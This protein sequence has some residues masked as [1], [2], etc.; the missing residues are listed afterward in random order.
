MKKFLLLPILALFSVACS[1][2]TEELDNY[3]NNAFRAAAQ[4]TAGRGKVSPCF[5]KVTAYPSLELQ[6]DVIGTGTL[7]FISQPGSDAG[8]GGYFVRVEV[9]QL[10]DCEDL[11]SGNGTVKVFTNGTIYYNVAANPPV[12]SGV[13][14]ADT[15]SCY[16]WRM[17][18]QSTG[19]SP[20]S[21]F[22]GWYDAPL[23]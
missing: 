6:N 3:E 18:F 11:N 15:F 14:P 16:R 19:S 23:F 5:S 4:T 22:S 20:C 10:S 9:E 12:V 21:V 13:S 1:S 2:D 17:V 8:T 7:S